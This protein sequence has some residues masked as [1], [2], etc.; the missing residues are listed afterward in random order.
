M[1]APVE[2]LT[3]EI[4]NV[5]VLMRLV[6]VDVHIIEPRLM[7]AK[8]PP[9]P[10]RLLFW[11]RLLHRRPSQQIV[12]TDVIEISQLLQGPSRNIVLTGLVF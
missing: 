9:L 6:G 10:R 2:Y 4:R 1:L 7:G 12:H 5:S 3:Y 8:K 11:I